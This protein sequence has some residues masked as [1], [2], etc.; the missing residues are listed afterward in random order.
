MVS[1]RIFKS[2]LL[3]AF[4]AIW[5]LMICVRYA[6]Y[7]L[8]VLCFILALL[9]SVITSGLIILIWIF[10]KQIVKNSM[11]LTILF[12]ITS[13]PVSI[14]LFLELFVRFIGQYGLKH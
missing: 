4:L 7:D 9:I 10:K 3:V 13:S 5:V 11:R 6:E 2:L 14:F 8:N 12:L 1:A